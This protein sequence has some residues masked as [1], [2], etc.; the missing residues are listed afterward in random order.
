MEQSKF[1]I[2]DRKEQ[3]GIEMIGRVMVIENLQEEKIKKQQ[4][5]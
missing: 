4:R 3:L 2:E 5:W 1:L